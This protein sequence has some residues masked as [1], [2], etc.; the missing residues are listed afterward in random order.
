MPSDIE[1]TVLQ[2]AAVFA[3]SAAWRAV[4]RSR[5]AIARLP[6]VPLAVCRASA[7][8]ALAHPRAAPTLVLALVGLSS[9]LALP[10]EGATAVGASRSQAGAPAARIA[11]LGAGPAFAAPLTAGGDADLTFLTL[12]LP[13]A[14]PPT[15]ASDGPGSNGIYAAD[16]TLLKPF[17]LLGDIAGLDRQVGR[18]TVMAGDTLGR[19]A[20]RFG[21]R[22]STIFW[23]NR[24]VDQDRLRLGQILLIPPIDG[25]LYAVRKGDTIASIATALHADAGRI[26][27]YNHLLGDVLVTGES[28]MVPDGRVAPTPA[29]APAAVVPRSITVRTPSPAGATSC[30]GWQDTATPPTTIRVLRTYGSAAGTVQRVA[31]RWYVESVMAAEWPTY[32]PTAALRAGAIAVK[33]YAWYRAMHYRGGLNAHR[34]CYDVVDTTGDQIFRPETRSAT[35]RLKAAVAATWSMSLRRTE[36]GG[37]SRFMLTGY[38]TGTVATCGAEQNGYLLY[39][40]GAGDCA[41]QGMTLAQILR[42]YYGPTLVIIRAP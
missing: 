42:I 28:L 37:S 35:T 17:A 6:E 4:R 11:A 30:T 2:N 29:W 9:L 22:M 40:K 23:T 18:Y 3:R 34:V 10:S 32:L 16:G 39:E 15:Y 41:R 33:Q 7:L 25:V 1:E 38:R 5:R 12:D 8:D 26:V 20:K 31:F 36:I 27:A 19:I 21:L 24:L 14:T 13:G